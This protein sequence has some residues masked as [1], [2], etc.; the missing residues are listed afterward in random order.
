MAFG[1]GPSGERPGIGG[2]R[3]PPVTTPPPVA[4]PPA[5]PPVL[6][7][8]PARQNRGG[9]G[10]TNRLPNSATDPLPPMFAKMVANGMPEAEARR[11][12]NRSLTNRGKV[13]GAAGT[14]VP[15]PSTPTTTSPPIGGPAVPS[16]SPFVGEV[17]PGTPVGSPG[18]PP[19]PGVPPIT[20]GSPVGGGTGAL[21]FRDPMQQFLAAVPIMNANA[22]RQIGDAMAGAGF[23]GNRWGTS[24]QNVAGQIGAENAMKQNALM[25]N[26][27]GDFAN[28]QEDRSL[29]ATGMSMGLGQM[30]DQMAQDRVRLPL[31]VGQYEQG[32]QDKFAGD[33]Y[34]M[35][36]NEKLG[37][38]P[39]MA[40]LA[41]SQGA[42]SPGQVYST[43]E[44]GKPGAADWLSILAQFL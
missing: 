33:R 42:G 7:G 38:L 40:D 15:S 24:A 10:M 26:L 25:A 43:T 13:P 16:P 31:E 21:D 37:W 18:M 44:P 20:G 36:E 9:N 35:Y 32:R 1:A 14:P 29:Q 39:F 4:P 19:M 41:K 28:K 3:N 11:R 27:L 12:W 2:R 6:P 34:K 8:Q 22:T 23:T 5:A 30:L 17:A